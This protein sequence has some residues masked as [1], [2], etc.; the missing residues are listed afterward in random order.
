MPRRGSSTKYFLIIGVS[1]VV[2][3]ASA[4]VIALFATGVL[5]SDRDSATAGARASTESG[6]EVPSVDVVAGLDDD[7]VRA[8]AAV[9]DDLNGMFD[10]LF[11]SGLTDDNATEFGYN[12]MTLMPPSLT[13]SIIAQECEGDADRCAQAIGG[14]TGSSFFY[15]RDAIDSAAT[16]L[17]LSLGNV[18]D[19]DELAELNDGLDGFGLTASCGC[20]V[21]AWVTVTIAEDVD[22]DLGYAPG[23]TVSDDWTQDFDDLFIVK[24]DGTWYLYND[25]VGRDA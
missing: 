15:S 21:K 11:A 8:A 17:D 2:I 24:I 16:V 12:V 10:D 4:V 3:V 1:A 13:E 18:L 20:S 6:V 5:G 25:V 23:E 19:A 14:N 7:D 9:V 22:D